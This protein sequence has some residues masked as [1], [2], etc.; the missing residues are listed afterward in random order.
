MSELPEIAQ[1]MLLYAALKS[2]VYF[3]FWAAV[4]VVCFLFSYYKLREPEDRFYSDSD[5]FLA[6]TGILCGVAA[7]LVAVYYL[8]VFIEVKL[9]P[10]AWLL[11]RAMK[12]GFTG[13]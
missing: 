8:L 1:Q 3:W 2:V 5:G 12:L 9:A 13:G 7:A 4:T 10:S 11:E 6:G